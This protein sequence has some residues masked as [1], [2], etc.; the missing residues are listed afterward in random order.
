M[1][2]DVW[3]GPQDEWPRHPKKHFRDALDYARAA[4]WH[5][6]E[7]SGHSFSKVYCCRVPDECC[8]YLVFSSGRGG[9]SAAGSLTNLVDRCTHGPVPVPSPAQDWV[10]GIAARLDQVQTMLVAAGDCLSA[11]AGAAAAYD[12]L[13]QAGA[14]MGDVEQLLAAAQTAEDHAIEVVTDRWSII[15]AQAP[16]LPF[17]TATA[18]IIEHVHQHLSKTED[19]L[20]EPPSGQIPGLPDLRARAAGLRGDLDSLRAQL[21]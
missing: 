21:P 20:T 3:Y 2:E 13:D 14:A 19:E 11:D 16:G 9:E 1:S 8:S 18:Q 6:R 12:L 17:P 4:G 10:E 7:I 15:N 5:L